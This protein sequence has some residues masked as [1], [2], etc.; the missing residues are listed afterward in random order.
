MHIDK[1][2][3]YNAWK[4]C[5]RRDREFRKKIGISQNM[6][7]TK[8]MCQSLFNMYRNILFQENKKAF[9]KKYSDI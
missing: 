1:K 5:Q 7:E 8:Q 4:D 2:Q 3:T 9:Y 6:E